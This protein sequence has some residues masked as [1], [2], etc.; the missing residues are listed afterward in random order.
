MKLLDSIWDQ[1]NL[2]L[3]LIF[4]IRTTTISWVVLKLRHHQWPRTVPAES[5]HAKKEL[6]DAGANLSV[7]GVENYNIQIHKSFFYTQK[8]CKRIFWCHVLHS[9]TFNHSLQATLGIRILMKS[10][11]TDFSKCC[12]SEEEMYHREQNAVCKVIVFFKVHPRMFV[13]VSGTDLNFV[14]WAISKRHAHI[15]TS[16]IK[17]INK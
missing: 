6:S 15:S 14:M 3:L 10:F 16:R 5:P 12:A 2:A 13:I 7:F 8:K 1:N 17:N 4:A 11:W 9:I